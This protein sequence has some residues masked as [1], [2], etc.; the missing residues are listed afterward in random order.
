MK[1]GKPKQISVWSGSWADE[2][3]SYFKVKKN[4]LYCLAATFYSRISTAKLSNYFSTFHYGVIT[5][6]HNN[7]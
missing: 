5:S 4:I 6:F 1:S 3:T 7:D 2:I